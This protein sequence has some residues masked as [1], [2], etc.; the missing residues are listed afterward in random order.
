MDTLRL[1]IVIRCADFERSRDF[2]ARV[3]GLPILQE[4]SEP[5]G[6]GCVFGFGDAR[7]GPAGAEPSNGGVL[8][9]YGMTREDP[10]FRD[11]F[12]RPASSDKI[13]IQLKTGSITDWVDRL[14]GVWPIEA[15]D[16]LPWG[17]RWLKLRDPDNLLVCIYQD[18][19]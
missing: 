9:I 15:L 7:P 14:R 11:E 8:E 1:K 3:L 12:T 18:P 16:K 17:Q 5:Q 2:Y 13:D 4:W 19:E 6:Q 10:R